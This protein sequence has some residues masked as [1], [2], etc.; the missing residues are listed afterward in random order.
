MTSWSEDVI[1]SAVNLAQRFYQVPVYQP[2]RLNATAR[3]KQVRL[4][5]GSITFTGVVD[6]IGENWVLDYKSDRF[7]TPEH[8]RFQLWAYAH[9]LGY[10]EAHIAYLRL[11]RLHSFDAAELNS[12]TPEAEDLVAQISAGNYQAKPSEINCST[13]PYLSIC[14]FAIF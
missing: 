6:L 13:C 7:F 11:D 3:E 1:Q 9:A 10:K 2:F 14:E 12:L 5:L 8:H 4:Q